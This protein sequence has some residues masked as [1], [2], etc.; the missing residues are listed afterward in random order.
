MPSIVS[1]MPQ[2]L[3]AYLRDYTP[4]APPSPSPSSPSAASAAPAARWGGVPPSI[5]SPAFTPATTPS[6]PVP[7]PVNSAESEVPKRLLKELPE[8][9]CVVRAR[10]PT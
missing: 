2:P 10:I 9:T 8:V 3:P 5:I 7:V 4:A 1:P 6:T